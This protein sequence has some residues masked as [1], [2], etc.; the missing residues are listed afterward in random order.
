MTFC[1]HWDLLSG[2]LYWD[3]S[4]ILYGLCARGLLKRLNW[5]GKN[6]GTTMEV[7]MIEK[8]KDRFDLEQEIL[9]CWNVTDDI[10]NYAAESATSEEFSALAQYY[11]RKFDRLWNTFESMIHERKM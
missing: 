9:Q 1:K 4:G 8:T 11:E 3:T 2:V 7:E 5:L 6:G 10:K